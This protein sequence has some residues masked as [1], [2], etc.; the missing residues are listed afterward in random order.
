MG[1]YASGAQ[2]RA[3]GPV[4]ARAA[5]L[6]ADLVRQANHVLAGLVRGCFG[7]R[8]GQLARVAASAHRPL[9]R[10]RERLQVGLDLVVGGATEQE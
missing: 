2:G 9:G 1:A 4:E 3:V 7:S 5:A 10:R 6:D 8:E